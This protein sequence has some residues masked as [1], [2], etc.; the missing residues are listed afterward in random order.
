MLE[1]STELS[2]AQISIHLH[3]LGILFKF[4]VNS[5]AD[6]RRSNRPFLEDKTE[7]DFFQIDVINFHLF[8]NYSF[9]FC[10]R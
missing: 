8:L 2:P 3:H 1:L 6:I 7:D 5:V 4:L 10:L 9:L